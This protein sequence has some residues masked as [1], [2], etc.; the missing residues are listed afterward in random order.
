MEDY[1][2][3][4]LEQL[5]KNIQIN[6]F[7]KRGRDAIAVGDIGIVMESEAIRKEIISQLKTLQTEMD[8]YLGDLPKSI[9]DVSPQLKDQ[10]LTV[11]KQLHEVIE[12]TIAIDKENEIKLRGLKEAIGAKIKEVGRGKKALG[13]YKSP[14]DRKPKLF[15]GEV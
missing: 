10:V 3:L 7:A 2:N 12:E 6:E 4:L 11:S 8:L 13:G 1:L 15:D 9:E 14:N 5:N